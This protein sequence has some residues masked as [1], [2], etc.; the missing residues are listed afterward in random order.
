MVK[1]AGDAYD[2]GKVLISRCTMYYS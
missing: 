2:C 1:L